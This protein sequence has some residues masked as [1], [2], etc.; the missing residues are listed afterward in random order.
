[1]STNTGVAPVYEIDITVA[2]NVI[3]TVIT[4]SPCPIPRASKARCNALVPVFTPVQY[5]AS[6]KEEKLSS[7]TS[8]SFPKLYCVH[9]NVFITHN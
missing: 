6:K 4:S 8:T 7:N 1:M 9:L 2:M 3:D 5:F